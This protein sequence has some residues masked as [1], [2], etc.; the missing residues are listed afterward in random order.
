[1]KGKTPTSCPLITT[2]YTPQK[3]V[4]ENVRILVTLPQRR[5]RQVAQQGERPMHV[6]THSSGQ[7]SSQE[8]CQG[9]CTWFHFGG[10]MGVGVADD[11][12]ASLYSQVIKLQAHTL[13]R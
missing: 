11:P 8:W 13:P 10:G 7:R 9:V 12:P 6:L 3:Q 1:M 5:P 2:K 4:K